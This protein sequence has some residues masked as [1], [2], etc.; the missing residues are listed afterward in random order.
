MNPSS[1]WT[2]TPLLLHGKC[3][4]P[5]QDWS[6]LSKIV[7]RANQTRF[8]APIYIQQASTAKI[9]R[10]IIKETMKPLLYHLRTTIKMVTTIS[11]E[12]QIQNIT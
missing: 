2:S 11:I 5:K 9:S 3:F 10:N 6:L 8:R 12:Y 4:V 1:D 7:R